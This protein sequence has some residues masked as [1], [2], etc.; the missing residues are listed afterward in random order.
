MFIRF[1][2]TLLAKLHRISVHN[3]H[4]A[5][6]ICESF[7]L[8]FGNFRVPS[9]HLKLSPHTEVYCQKLSHQAVLVSG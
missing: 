9:D 1:A 5:M 6:S 4:A 7:I 2:S 3:K 8:F